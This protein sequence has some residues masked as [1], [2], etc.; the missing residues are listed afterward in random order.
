M[1]RMYLFL[2]LLIYQ[3]LPQNIQM[4]RVKQKNAGI[5]IYQ[6]EQKAIVM[7]LKRIVSLLIVMAYGRYTQVF[8]KIS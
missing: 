5:I 8:T 1:K 7:T 4:M 6:Q 2:Y 3:P